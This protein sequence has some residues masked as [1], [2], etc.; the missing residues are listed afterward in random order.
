MRES[1][2]QE[3]VRKAQEE[4]AKVCTALISL[5]QRFA[6][7]LK[8]M[9]V[10]YPGCNEHSITELRLLT[11]GWLCLIRPLQLQIKYV[12]LCE[13]VLVVDEVVTGSGIDNRDHIRN[14]D[15][16]NRFCVPI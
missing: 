11:G 15:K 13:N 8:S 5:V 16:V 3:I 4:E 1:H 7:W 10:A 14:W 2:L 12:S 6:S 9:C